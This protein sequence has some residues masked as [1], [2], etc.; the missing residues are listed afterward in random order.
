MTHAGILLFL[1]LIQAK[2]YLADFHWQT[3]EM[4]RNKGVYLHPA[5][6]AHAGLHALLSLPVMW[7]AGFGGAAFILVLAMAELV[8]HL[9]IDWLKSRLQEGRQDLSDPVFWKHVGLDQAAHQ[10]TYAA[11]LAIALI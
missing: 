8:V 3:G 5:A 9:H 11:M 6:L 2:H 10:L 4:I 7:L 1:V